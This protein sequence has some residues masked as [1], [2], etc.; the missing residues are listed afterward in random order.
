MAVRRE[1]SQQLRLA[2]T[3][4]S[5]NDVYIGQGVKGMAV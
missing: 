4:H 2:F 5:V 1:G 3:Q